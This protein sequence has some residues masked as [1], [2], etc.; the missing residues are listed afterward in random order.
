[1]VGRRLAPLLVGVLA[2]AGCWG[3]SLDD[4]EAVADTLGAAPT[5]WAQV[6]EEIVEDC[7]DPT[8]SC[9]RIVRTY[10]LSPAVD[11]ATSATALV[12]D[13]GLEVTV[14]AL[15]GCG[16]APEPGCSV[17]ARGD[18]VAVRATVTES[19]GDGATVTVRITEYVGP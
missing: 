16:V 1:M 11:F 3:P 4:L 17:R 14:P 13:A 5:G 2:I 10:T 12:L 19:S 15:S 9:P 6:D 7:S 18:D 8:E